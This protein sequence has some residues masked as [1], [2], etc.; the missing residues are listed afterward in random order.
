VS[1]TITAIDERLPLRDPLEVK[2][3]PE[4]ATI[5]ILPMIRVER[6][7]SSR[8]SRNEPLPSDSEP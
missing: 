3:L 7:K 4:P 2:L 1:A 8:A 5:I 6:P